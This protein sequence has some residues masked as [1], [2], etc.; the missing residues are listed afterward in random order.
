M[1]ADFEF[2]K[3]SINSFCSPNTAHGSFH[4]QPHAKDGMFFDDWQEHPTA[5][6]SKALFWEYDLSSPDW[7][8]QKM[9][10]IVVARV[11]ALG[12]PEEY[13]AMFHLYGGVEEVKEIVKSL[14]KLNDSD[15]HWCCFLFSLEKEEL[16]SYQRKLL[17]R[18]F[19]PSWK[20]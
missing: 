7:D 8:W 14:P 9:R 15:M 1:S 17:R 11:I 19:L 3:V 13:Y 20:I 12:R 4:P 6:F 18:R 5:S 2:F 16:W 10:Q